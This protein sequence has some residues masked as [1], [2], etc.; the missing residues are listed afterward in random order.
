MKAHRPAPVIE[1]V[2]ERRPR[3]ALPAIATSLKRVGRML[4][5]S[6]ELVPQL[7]GD[8]FAPPIRKPRTRPSA[9]LISLFGMVVV[10]AAVAGIY[11][12]FMASDQYVAEARF[13][14]RKSQLEMGQDNKLSSML[15]SF[16]SGGSSGGLADQEAHIVANYLRS[17]AAVDDVSA[18][19]NVP[20]IF[21][22]P[23]ADFWARLKDKPTSEELVD[24]WR[25]MVTTYVDGPSGVVTVTARAFRA[26]DAKSL[27][28]EFISTSEALVNRL[29]ERSR[30]DAM[31]KAEIEVRKRE[32]Q[33]RQSLIDLRQYRDQEG[34]INPLA[35]AT[36]TTKLL[37]E[38]MSDRIKLQ[39]DYFVASR[40][41]SQEAPTLQTLKSRLDSVDGQIDKLKAQLTTKSSEARSVSASLVRFEE[42]E[43]Q[44]IFSEKMYTMSQDALERARLRA[45]Q[46]TIYVAVFVPPFL[47]QEARFPERLSS[48]VLIAIGLL[49]IWGIASPDIGWRNVAGAM[50]RAR[51]AH[52]A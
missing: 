16:T 21:Q 25:K 1:T 52:A 50:A 43:L 39:S 32:A 33:V 34:F 13:A 15:S 11:L 12:A 4:G 42:L 7:P 10:P 48:T 14:V 20:A 45:E 9:Y 26:E 23:E 31:R 44:R 49:L 3:F 6:S 41:M 35:A 30:Q 38:A 18:R 19:L 40:A 8:S 47:P 46:Q 17:R 22:R 51:G 27:V 2:V 28:Q 24:Y 36:S 37:M 5:R 29:S